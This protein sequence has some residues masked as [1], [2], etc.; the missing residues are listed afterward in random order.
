MQC[1]LWSP[2]EERVGDYLDTQR[3]RS[4]IKT[5]FIFQ[6]SHLLPC[7][8]F[9]YWFMNPH[10]LKYVWVTELFTCKWI[11][12]MCRFLFVTLYCLLHSC[13]TICIKFIHFL[14]INVI[15]L[16][17]ILLVSDSP[18]GCL[19]YSYFAIFITQSFSFKT[20]LLL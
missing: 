10:N 13:L 9:Y 4:F 14:S 11:T 15:V 7:W 8:G 5:S 6:T 17:S 16:N 18:L 2:K 3:Y 1:D 20:L 12:F 19:Q